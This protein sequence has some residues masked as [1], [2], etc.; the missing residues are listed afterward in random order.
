MIRKGIT[1]SK[2]HSPGFLK[3][4]EEA[5]SK[6]KEISAEDFRHE[7]TTNHHVIL[8][9]VREDHEWNDGSIKGAIHLGR[10][11]LERDVEVKVP[12]KDAPIVLYCGGGYR[13]ALAAHSLG[14]MGYSNVRSL[15]GGYRR[16]LDLGYEI[17]K[18][19]KP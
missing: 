18:G 12:Q 16:W 4:A 14:Q 11:I 9:D 13:S 2:S 7:M 1:V 17:Q 19:K 6:I 5:R 8:L 3:I 10:G 15:A